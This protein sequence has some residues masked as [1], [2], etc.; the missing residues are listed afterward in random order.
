MEITATGVIISTVCL[1]L[2]A[3]ATLTVTAYI[4]WPRPTQPPPRRKRK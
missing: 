3:V 2:I 4:F 1:A